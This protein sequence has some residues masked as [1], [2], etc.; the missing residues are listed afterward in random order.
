MTFLLAQTI[1]CACK[2]SHLR[3]P[4]KQAI[5]RSACLCACKNSRANAK[6]EQRSLWDSRF[7]N[8]PKPN[9]FL[10]HND[11]MAVNA[12]THPSIHPSIPAWRLKSWPSPSWWEPCLWFLRDA[13]SSCGF[14]FSSRPLAETMLLSCISFATCSSGSSHMTQVIKAPSAPTSSLPHSVWSQKSSHGPLRLKADLNTE[15][16][17]SPGQ[18]RWLLGRIWK[19]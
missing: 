7:S 18:K 6:A 2:I 5:V 17:L 12:N 1:L 16:P 15:T 13:W 4:V 10:T 9:A 8:Q 11:L 14:F 19:A 3:L